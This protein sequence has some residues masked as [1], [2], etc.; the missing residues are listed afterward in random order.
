MGQEPG[1]GLVRELEGRAEA[2]A[3]TFSAQEVGNTLLAACVFSLLFD[4]GQGWRWVHTV[5]RLVSLGEAACFNAA[6]LCGLCQ[7]HQFLVCCRVEPRL[8][9]DA[10][11]W[12]VIQPVKETCREAFE[13]A[14]SAPSATK[15][16]VSETVP[17]I[18][19]NTQQLSINTRI[20][21]AARRRPN[22]E[23]A[24]TPRIRGR[25]SRTGKPQK[26]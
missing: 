10:T 24:A 22:L 19:R 16:Q 15:Q 21:L 5:Q 2:L 3:G 4:S 8:C 9:M 25:W 14:K 12:A 6:Q 1:T 18:L 11:K 13:C 17:R 7:I 20:P 26:S 23:K